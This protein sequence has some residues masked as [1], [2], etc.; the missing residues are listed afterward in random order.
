MN[1]GKRPSIAAAFF[2]FFRSAA[3][4]PALTSQGGCLSSPP[5]PALVFSLR[6]C[7]LEPIPSFSLTQPEQNLRLCL[8]CRPA[9]TLHGLSFG[10]RLKSLPALNLEITC[11]LHDIMS[12]MQNLPRG[13]DNRKAGKEDRKIVRKGRR[14]RILHCNLPLS[15]QAVRVT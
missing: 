6:L 1:A 7:C 11:G 4:A 9:T 12:K 2:F 10:I 5:R 3:S 14:Y 8:V 15:Q 13:D